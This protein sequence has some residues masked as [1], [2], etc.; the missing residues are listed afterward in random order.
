MK[1][2]T[3]AIRREN[4]KRQKDFERNLKNSDGRPV[5]KAKATKKRS[6]YSELQVELGC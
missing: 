4:E 5:K 3:R 6:F 2:K 1:D